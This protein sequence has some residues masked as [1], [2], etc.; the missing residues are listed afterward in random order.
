MTGLAGAGL[1]IGGKILSTLGS[2]ISPKIMAGIFTGAMLVMGLMLWKAGHDRD[3]AVRDRNVAR[4]QVHQIGSAVAEVQG[5]APDTLQ[6]DKIADVVRVIG[7]DR[8]T[9]RRE[10]DRFM[11]TAQSQSQHVAALSAETA[12]LKVQANA[13]VKAV[14]KIT[15]DRDRW[16]SKAQ[17]ASERT[18]QLPT[19][20]ELQQT[21]DA[22]DALYHNG[23]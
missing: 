7:K 5:I 18:R 20:E 11:D 4:E 13:N 12:R 8:D 19:T 15:E 14:Q 23:F 10:R 22:L 16:I 21:E 1:G 17:E 2:L 6:P 9:A 3:A